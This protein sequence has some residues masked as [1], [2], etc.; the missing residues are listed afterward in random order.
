MAYA[1]PSLDFELPNAELQNAAWA[2]AA[3]LRR[4]RV[5]VFRAHCW[6]ELVHNFCRCDAMLALGDTKRRGIRS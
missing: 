2:L 4:R 5:P 3:A 6:P 1:I